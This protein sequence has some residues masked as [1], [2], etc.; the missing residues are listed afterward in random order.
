[1]VLLHPAV[2]PALS[3]SQ[4]LASLKSLPHV[5]QHL[6]SH[7]LIHRQLMEKT[8]KPTW[9]SLSVQFI[10]CS[11]SSLGLC[12]YLLTEQQVVIVQSTE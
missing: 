10:M 12:H 1:M 7:Q 11:T 9:Q 8:D 3:Q 6:Q 5:P 2:V 4:E